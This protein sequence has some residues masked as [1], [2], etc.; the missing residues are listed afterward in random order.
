MSFSVWENDE[1]DKSS[2]PDKF[3]RFSVEFN[4]I[5]LSNPADLDS[6]HNWVCEFSDR[7]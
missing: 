2:N 4:Q 7:N 1:F 3:A 5:S 6:K